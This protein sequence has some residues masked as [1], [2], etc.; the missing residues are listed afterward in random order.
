MKDYYYTLGISR[1]ASLSEIQQAYKKL[2]LKF[3]PE[4]NGH[5]P[6]Y[7]FHYEKVKEAYHILSDDHKRFRYDKA[8]EKQLSKEVEDILEA[9]T[10]VV[11]AFFASKNTVQKGDIITISW[12]VFNAEKVRINLIGEVSSNGTQ[13]IRLTVPAA[14]EPYLYLDLEASNSSS[15]QSSRKRLALRNTAYQPGLSSD[16]LPQPN[17]DSNWESIAPAA[18]VV[19]Q[20][21]PV[22][23]DKTNKIVKKTTKKTKKRTSKKASSKTAV[24]QQTNAWA[25]YLLVAVL[26]FM[27]AVM[28]YTLFLINPIF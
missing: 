19:E 5:D 8:F 2:S 6:F 28:L 13:T 12:E 21:E 27:I 26:F 9:P 11:A 7:T 18:I 10:P 17:T 23:E 16:P 22:E 25:A 20:E 14:N 24:N 3:H 1:E 4:K 15:I